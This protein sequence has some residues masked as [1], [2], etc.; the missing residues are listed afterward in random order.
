[1]RTITKENLIANLEPK[2]TVTEMKNLRLNCRLD[3]ADERIF[4]LEDKRNKIC[5]LNHEERKG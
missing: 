3:T 1:M 5:K 2:D 4:E